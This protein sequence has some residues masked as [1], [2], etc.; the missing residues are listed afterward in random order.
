MKLR[1]Y[2]LLIC[3]I[4]M[5][6]AC[7]DKEEDIQPAEKVSRTVLAY[8]VGD[9]GRNDLSS[10]L[11]K[12]FNDM[13]KGMES[14]DNSDCNMLVYSVMK[15][16]SPCLIH[17][18]K[19]SSK[20]SV[21]TLLVYDNKENPLDK[22]EMKKVMSYAFEYFP[23]D[24]YGYV[25][26]SHA[27]G[28]IP[29]TTKA[30]R[31]IGTYRNTSMDVDEFREV[32]SDVGKHLDFILFDACYMQSIEVAYELRDNADYFI[33][34]PTEIPGP[35]APY[36]KLMKCFFD[37]EDA[38]LNI[39]KGYYEAYAEKYTGRIPTNDNWT[40]GVSVSVI[41][42]DALEQLA[43]LTSRIFARYGQNVPIS[44]VMC[45]DLSGSEYYCDLDG[46][47]RTLTNE[48]ED[49][50]TWR[51]AFVNAR[52]YWGATLKNYS[53]FGMGQMF[54]MEDAEGISTY[55]P[56]GTP[57]SRANEY[58]RTYDWAVATEWGFSMM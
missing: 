55:I 6:G 52:P 43:D 37:R 44:N 58:Y 19:T 9:N 10:L 33:G 14:V 50:A 45:Y 57:T 4:G 40:G 25:F 8:I 41:K 21:D 7:Q 26:L 27:A 38:A 34:S 39:A 48:N 12:N 20:V 1:I 53:G 47:I 42:A 36:N 17:L 24:S 2:A 11:K 5:L 35:G 54:S 13:V 28:W 56:S 32:L 18:K 23:A 51:K 15:N 31:S 46:L 49:Y 30:S 22:E 3:L 16:Q 29:A